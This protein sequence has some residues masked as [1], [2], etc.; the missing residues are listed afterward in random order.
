MLYIENNLLH[1]IIINKEPPI[2]IDYLKVY[3][4]YIF[5]ILAYNILK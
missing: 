2:I 4:L 1:Y 3:I 5:F